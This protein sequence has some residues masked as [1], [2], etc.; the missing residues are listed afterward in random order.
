MAV[1]IPR[2]T[3]TALAFL[4]VTVAPI[5]PAAAG[6]TRVTTAQEFRT[7]VMARG[8]S[9]VVVPDGV[10]LA[11]TT[12]M[13]NPPGVISVSGADVPAGTAPTSTI[14]V[15]DGIALFTIKANATDNA[16]GNFGGLA[17]LNITRTG[18]PAA[19]AD[20]A[21]AGTINVAGAFTGGITN[22]ATTGHSTTGAGSFLAA[23][24]FTG[25]IADSTFSGN[26]SG[27][28]GGAITVNGS[29]AGGITNSVFDGNSAKTGSAGFHSYV[30]P[31]TDAA[32]VGDVRD[33]VFSNNQ[34][35][36]NV[37]GAFGLNNVRLEGDVV[38]SKFLNNTNSHT[39]STF[40]GGASFDELYGKIENSVFEGNTAVSQNSKNGSGGAFYAVHLRDGI[41]NSTFKGNTAYLGGAI[42]IGNKAMQ[43]DIVGSDF[44]ENHALS[45]GGALYIGGKSGDVMSMHGAIRNSR[46]IRNSSVSGGGAIILMRLRGGIHDSLF[47]GNTG[48]VGGA[49]AH[50]ASSNGQYYGDIEG[51]I[52]NSRFISNQAVTTG[53]VISTSRDV[54]GDI[55][56]SRFEDNAVTN[57]GATIRINRYYN[58]N[59]IESVFR[60]NSAGG[61]GFGGAGLLAKAGFTGSVQNSQFIDNTGGSDYGGAI[62]V[63]AGNFAADISDSTFT[64]NILGIASLGNEQNTRGGALGISGDIIGSMTNTTFSQNSAMGTESWGGAI[65]AAKITGSVS[66]GTFS[67]NRAGY[68]GAIYLVSG[69]DG[70]GSVIENTVFDQNRANRNGGAVAVQTGA[71]T[72]RDATFTGNAALGDGGAIHSGGA[73][74]LAVTDGKTSLFS[75][76]SDASGGNAVYLGAGGSL[77][78]AVAGTGVLDMR[79]SLRGVA[80]SG[81]TL[82]IEKT[83]AGA[84]HLGG[85]S[86]ITSTGGSTRFSHAAGSLYLYHASGQ[87]GGAAVRAEAGGGFSTGRIDLEGAGSS[88][89]MAAGARLRVGGGNAITITSS[90]ANPAGGSKQGTLTFN[91]GNFDFDLGNA[92][93]STSGGYENPMLS[94]KAGRIDFNETITVNLTSVPTAGGYYVLVRKDA[95]SGTAFRL[96]D[97]VSS[98]VTYRG[99]AITSERLR[100]AFQVST[101][102]GDTIVLSPGYVFNKNLEWRTTDTAWTLN[103]NL[104]NDTGT[105]SATDTSFMPGDAVIFTASHVSPSI[106]VDE[107]MQ[108]S[109]LTVTG[110]SHSFT[111]EAIVSA[112]TV[113][114]PN[115]GT[116]DPVNLTKKATVKNGGEA[117]FANRI[118]FENGLDIESG[119]KVTVTNG[120]T[121]ADRMTVM[122]DGDLAFDVAAGQSYTRTGTL[123]GA[124]TVVKQNAGTFTLS[125]AEGF[126]GTFRQEA[127]VVELAGDIGSAYTQQAGT[128]YTQKGMTIGKD[129]SL[130]GTI[131]PGNRKS[132]ADLAIGGNLVLNNAVLE[133]DVTNRTN[134]AIRVDGAVNFSGAN[135]VSI[136]LGEWRSGKYTLMTGASMN[137]AGA[138]ITSTGTA[139]NGRRHHETY[140][141]ND[142]LILELTNDNNRNLIW[143]GLDP[144]HSEKWFCQA[145]NW[146]TCDN[147]DDVTQFLDGDAVIFDGVTKDVHVCKP[148]NVYVSSLL[149]RNGATVSFYN[150]DEVSTIVS[151]S[152]D[153]VQQHPGDEITV[154]KDLRVTGENSTAHFKTAVSLAG[155]LKA[156]NGG[157]MRFSAG[158]ESAKGI[159]LGSAGRAVLLDGG[160]IADTTG[161]VF[162]PTLSSDPGDSLGV[163]ATRIANAVA[164]AAAPR[165]DDTA[166][167]FSVNR[168]E[169]YRWTHPLSGPGILRNDGAGILWFTDNLSWTDGTIMTENERL[170][171]GFADDTAQPATIDVGRFEVGSEGGVVFQTRYNGDAPN[172]IAPLLTADDIVLAGQVKATVTDLSHITAETDAVGEER[173][174]TVAQARNLLDLVDGVVLSGDRAL[175]SYRFEVNPDNANDL[176]LVIY[177]LI[178]ETDFPEAANDLLAST[179]SRNV[180]DSL[181]GGTPTPGGE[182]EAHWQEILNAEDNADLNRLVREINGT[183]LAGSAA[184]TANAASRLPG[185]LRK[186]PLGAPGILDSLNDRLTGDDALASPI[187]PFSAESPWRFLAGAIGERTRLRGTDG[188]PGFR[189]NTWGGAIAMDRMVGA[190]APGNGWRVGAAM[191]ADWSKLRWTENNG[192]ANADTVSWAV[193][194]K[195]EAGRWFASA[196]ADFGITRT[197]TERHLPTSGLTATAKYTSHYYGGALQGGCAA[198]LGHNFRLVAN[199]G[200]TYVHNAIPA[201]DEQGAGTLSQRLDRSSTNNLNL[202]L[203]VELSRLFRSDFRRLPLAWSPWLRVGMNAETWD[204]GGSITTRFIGEPDIPS[205]ISTSPDTGRV[206]LEIGAGVRAA[207]NQRLEM[208]LEYAGDFRDNRTRHAGLLSMELR[209]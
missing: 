50:A 187:L 188:E 51:G 162:D 39:T 65:S 161:I 104:W 130:A 98:T 172:L 145:T 186:N 192:S 137:S 67:Q 60:D 125:G 153:D 126:T 95:N 156:Y 2:S 33:S 128:L 167:V 151:T 16:L 108:V 41:F 147:D 63:Q 69:M 47:Q 46:F 111:G 179:N 20:A 73:V 66:G 8:D 30:F 77:T 149:V 27:G 146:R 139:D 131:S 183:Q 120:G 4:M 170:G 76:N 68:G 106:D 173:R 85:K 91:S 10:T 99:R 62:S 34:S 135:Q 15:A 86:A 154:S 55:V 142:S 185:W 56:N 70:T 1:K 152:A 191:E 14:E 28:A 52:T 123:T 164:G 198:D 196:M 32:F 97:T 165:A 118:D 195:A 144:S 5:R 121:L 166:G 29:F 150:V 26:V 7:A 181:F 36:V 82:V 194:A 79:D 59:I 124:G 19:S 44:I 35:G 93:N 180:M 71:I 37:G 190:A 48:P 6:E 21:G 132:L 17:N 176:D 49:I 11:I 193:Y 189:I 75:G 202:N 138:T 143:T 148:G 81:K 129:V 58:G 122:V 140:I 96:N 119:G 160:E 200:L 209:F 155:G 141:E 169:D 74:T 84:W 157:E 83:G 112:N 100:E 18:G 101:P 184:M 64:G 114:N 54:I 110:G 53:S 136:V 13:T 90:A 103:D 42:Y 168:R 205:F 175:Y 25:G 197:K 31:G 78:A 89:T 163:D 178:A 12:G 38:N 208:A 40:G 117:T 201:V 94:L 45:Q 88:F 43:G 203:S 57:G 159:I 87:A 182:L 9:D 24:S 199:G 207:I 107:E 158:V 113:V 72:F 3:L 23:A 22:V 105:A 177:P 206:G 61:V 116:T 115:G 133:M 174:T 171:I 204:Q 80:A 92:V 127:G 109:S 134:D 102:D